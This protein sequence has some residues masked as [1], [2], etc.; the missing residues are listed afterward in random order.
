MD[1]SVI[2]PIYNVEKYIERC[3]LSLFTQTKTDGVEFILVDDCS[4]DCTMQIAKKILTEYPGIEV[5]IIEHKVNKGISSTRQSGIDVAEGKYIYQMD[6]DDWCE[7]TMLEELYNFANMED[8]DIV[9]CD[10]IFDYGK[11]QEYYSQNIYEKDGMEHVKLILLGKIRVNLFIRLI[12]RSLLV[13]NNIRF[14]DGMRMGEDSLI[15]AK[16]YSMTKNVAYLPKA[17]YHYITTNNNSLCSNPNV[18]TYKE[19]YIDVPRY[20]E[21]FFIEYNLLRELESYLIK[22]KLFTKFAILLRLKPHQRQDFANIH[23]EVNEYIWSNDSMSMVTKFALYKATR[24]QMWIFN[25][26][27]SIREFLWQFKYTIKD[28]F[29]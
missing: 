28:M 10:Y 22:R 5:K 17:F 13:D 14:I 26:I 7:A 9:T 12:R 19:L 2:V 23:P 25:I 8:A 20:M 24:G 21:Q 1:I 15:L 18:D 6:S 27:C 11:T 16:L 3:L 4:S 29:K